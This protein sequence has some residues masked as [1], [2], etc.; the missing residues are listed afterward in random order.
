MEGSTTAEALSTTIAPST[1][2]YRTTTNPLTTAEAATTANAP[3]SASEPHSVT[4]SQRHTTVFPSATHTVAGKTAATLT[5]AS[6]TQSVISAN[7]TD[8]PITIPFLITNF[9]A[10]SAA[11]AAPATDGL[12]SASST[13]TT[14]PV[15]THSL[16]S[17][18]TSAVTLYSQTT[19]A[20]AVA[21]TVSPTV[22]GAT[23]STVIPTTAEPPTIVRT[24]VIFIKLVFHTLKPV[25]SEDKILELTNGLLNPTVRQWNDLINVDNATFDKLSENSFSITLSY[26]ITELSMPKDP[27]LRNNVY[28]DIEDSVNT[29]LNNVLNKPGSS[30]FE[31]PK[32]TYRDMIT[33]IH[34]DVV[35]VYR[36]NDIKEPSNF[37]TGIINL[38]GVPTTTVP[39]TM[40][41]AAQ[42]LAETST[43]AEATTKRREINGSVVI[44][45]RLVFP[46]LKSVPSESE[47]LQ[48]ANTHLDAPGRVLN[49]PVMVDNITY[50]SK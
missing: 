45:I 14:A 36:E 5:T 42:I 24:V 46:N 31:F 41:S 28:D 9:P 6:T 11:A 35:Y 47:V 3:K 19:P 23:T 29:L 2:K 1:T 48:L 33:E 20:S 21:V 38:I 50:E 17:S 25:P 15:G 12:N 18:T 30:P 43:Q 16:V 32:P 44:I 26:K 10:S 39:I 49:R 34:A 37:L 7:K 4:I 8:S 27:E 13:T 22:S 40:T